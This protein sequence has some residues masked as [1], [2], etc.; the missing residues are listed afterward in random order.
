MSKFQYAPGIPGYGTKGTD[1]SAGLT[2]LG[3]YFT[4]YDGLTSASTIAGRLLASHNLYGSDVSIA[5][6]GGGRRYQNGEMFVD[7]WGRVYEIN[8]STYP[9][10]VFTNQTISTTSFFTEILPS[11]T[12]FTRIA[13]IYNGAELYTLDNVYSTT[14]GNYTGGTNVPSNIY[15]ILPLNFATIQY[16]DINPLNISAAASNYIPFTVY[17]TGAS[18]PGPAESD[19]FAIVKHKTLPLWR[20]GNLDGETNVRDVSLFLDFREVRATRNFKVDGSAVFMGDV[21][22]RKELIVGGN[23]YFKNDVYFNDN[24][25]NTGFY[26][27]RI[28]DPGYLQVETS[29]NFLYKTIRWR[30]SATLLSETPNMYF[31]A[32]DDRTNETDILFIESG[33]GKITKGAAPTSSQLQYFG[34]GIDG[35]LSLDST[36]LALQRDMFYEDVCIKHPPSKSPDCPKKDWVS[37]ILT[38]ISPDFA[39]SLS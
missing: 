22:I 13:N 15:N 6:W 38:E 37:S 16:N 27:K 21:S 17:S 31:E 18:W 4:E 19:S 29:I 28:L 1:G 12:G 20:I 23:A 24:I 9:Y 32:L 36:E 30:S 34:G 5:G 8:F 11:D 26:I 39:L 7:I 14:V 25:H 33:T 3:M 10:Y 35:D 2:G